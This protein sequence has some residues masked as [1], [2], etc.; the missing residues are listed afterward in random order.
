MSSCTNS[1]NI[2]STI[3]SQVI[4][5]TADGKRV[6]FTINSNDV[7][8]TS[9]V[10]LGSVI[11]F[12][13]VTDSYQLSKADN[14]ATAEV[15]GVVESILGDNYT[16]VANGLMVY[17]N[18]GS[19]INSYADGCTALDSGTDGGLGGGDIFFLSDGCE[20]KL[21]YLE[22]TTPGYIVKPV[23]Q[24]VKVGPS[25]PSQYNAIV[26]NYIG[27]EVAESVAVQAQLQQLVGTV[28]YAKETDATLN[29]FIKV[30]SQQLL[31]TT[32]YPELYSVFATNYGEYEETISIPSYAANIAN[33]TNSTM[34]QKTGSRVTSTGTVVFANDANKTITVRKSKT[35]PKTDTS[36]LVYFGN[37]AYT[38]ASSNVTSFTLPSTPTQKIKY[39]ANGVETEETLIPYMKSKPDVDYVSIPKTIEIEEIT[40]DKINTGGFVVGSKLLDLEQRVANMERRYGIP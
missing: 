10:T 36:K 34:T 11:R 2:R 30:D 16:V 19:V 28:S 1:S 5:E 37:L 17:P 13:M 18:I 40:S 39:V 35:E 7:G 27:Y 24:R 38:P 26:L 23:M 31:S 33:L 8:I 14:P 6:V 25:G 22:P 20:G 32:S 9:G 12:D 3:L 29:G 4:R 15:V 21:Q